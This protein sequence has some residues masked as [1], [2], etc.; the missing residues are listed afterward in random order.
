MVDDLAIAVKND[1]GRVD[2][3]F[4]EGAFSAQTLHL[5]IMPCHDLVCITKFCN[6]FKPFYVVYLSKSCRGLIRK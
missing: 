4:K 1:F 2:K 6:D 3:R 5:E